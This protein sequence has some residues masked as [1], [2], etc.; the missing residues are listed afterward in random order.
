M[1]PIAL[2]RASQLIHVTDTLERLGFSAERML[3]Q[4]KLPLWHYCDPDDLI[5]GH[6]V[7][8]LL[9]QAARNLG[10]ASFGL[11]VGADNSV[12]TLGTFGRL[13]MSSPTIHQAFVTACRLIHLHNTGSHLSLAE[14]GD[15]V[16]FGHSEFPSPKIGRRQKELYVLMR[17]IEYGGMAAGP[18]WRPT[19]VCLQRR[20]PPEPE[21]REAL[22]DPEIRIGQMITGI[23]MPR[24]LLAQPLQR[25]EAPGEAVDEVESRLRRTAPADSFVDT[26]RQLTATLLKQEEGAPQVETMAEITGLSIRSLQ[27]HLAKDGLSH[28]EIVDQARYQAAVCQLEDSDKRITDI[29]LDLGYAD[30]A[31]FT[32]AFKRWAGVTPREYRNKQPMH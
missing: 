8:A 3:E 13:V 10:S 1:Q 30:S 23:A 27:R 32:R 24:A 16:W 11:L 26:L 7:H 14:V 25:S 22:G 9:H 12:N 18:S 28:S 6:H 21:L 19:K 17:L 5:P 29:G 4:A 2:T 15:D 20:E 31:H